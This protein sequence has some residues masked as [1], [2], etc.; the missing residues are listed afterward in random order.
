MSR[1]KCDVSLLPSPGKFHVIRDSFESVDDVTNA[2]KEA[3]VVN[4]GLIIGF[5]MQ[6]TPEE[7]NKTP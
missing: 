5:L 4:C 6:K 2:I 1:P 3:G 7:T